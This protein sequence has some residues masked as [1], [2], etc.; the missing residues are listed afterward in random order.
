MAL[1]EITRGGVTYYASDLLSGVPH[2][3][4][5]ARFLPALLAL[6][7]EKAPAY[8]ES[9]YREL[10]VAPEALLG[11]I[12]LCLP[13]NAITMTEEEIA[14][15]LPRWENNN[16]VRNTCCA[17]STAEIREILGQQFLKN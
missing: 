14:S 3:F 4:A 6:V 15:A 7:Q 1:H 12:R 8:A 11:L 16:S 9:F 13:E 17:V 10:G 2:G 5:S